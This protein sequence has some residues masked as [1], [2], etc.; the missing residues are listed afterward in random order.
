MFLS[1]STESWKTSGKS[2]YEHVAPEDRQPLNPD[3]QPSPAEDIAALRHALHC[4]KLW[5]IVVSVVFGLAILMV[6]GSRYGH[7]YLPARLQSL[8]WRPSHS[9]PIPEM[10]MITKAFDGDDR[11][12]HL[13]NPHSNQ[14]WYSI[15]PQGNGFITVRNPRLHKQLKPGLKTPKNKDSEVYTVSM[16]HQLHCL[17][18]IRSH[19]WGLD[20]ASKSHNQTA[21]DKL[22]ADTMHMDHCF[23]YVRQALMCAGDMTLEWPDFVKGEDGEEHRMDG[24]SIPHQCKSWVSLILPLMLLRTTLLTCVTG[25]YHVVHDEEPVFRLVRRVLCKYIHSVYTIQPSN[26]PTIS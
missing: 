12:A 9:G 20:S 6:A 19:L 17:I 1:K 16:F 13:S 23:D 24:E 14:M 5:L 8:Q 15:M 2:K 18:A 10:P 21:L 22:Y 25:Q 26:C 4:L 3:E 7:R 11:F